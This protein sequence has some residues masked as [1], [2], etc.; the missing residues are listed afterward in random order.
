MWAVLPMGAVL[1]LS[2][3]ALHQPHGSYVVGLPEADAGAISTRIAEIVV[4]RLPRGE[5]VSLARL[6]NDT[7]ATQEVAARLDEALRA[8]GLSIVG[9]TSD[10]HVLRYE[11]M[12]YGPS[13]LLRVYLDE[14][15]TTTV[16]TR[17][18]GGAWVVTAS[19]REEVR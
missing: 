8:R 4:A 5:K 14:A 3:C 17:G 2:A 10:G 7:G 19:P 13:W 11:V 16:M 6:A 15:E 1:T 12:P 9:A 18:Q